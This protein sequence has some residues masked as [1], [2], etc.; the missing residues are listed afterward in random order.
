M[1]HIVLASPGTIYLS[2]QVNYTGGSVAVTGYLAAV[3]LN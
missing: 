3:P 1:Q 2:T